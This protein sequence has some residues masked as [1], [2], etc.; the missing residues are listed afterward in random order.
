LKGIWSMTRVQK[1]LALVVVACLVGA[2]AFWLV[3]PRPSPLAASPA[4]P[5]ATA[6]S[7]SDPA[8]SAPPAAAPARR[9]SSTGTPQRLVAARV[10]HDP[11]LQH[12]AF[13]GQV[14]NFST[15]AGV[16]GAQVT[17]AHDGASQSVATDGDG[18][19]RFE[20]PAAGGYVLAV[21]TK[22]GFLPFAPEWGTSPI[23]L[24]ARPGLHIRDVTIYLTPA[25][26]YTG[27]VVDPDGAP[28]AG[29][30]V[31]LVGVS[32][33]QTLVPLVDRFVSDAHGEFVF[34]A[35][36]DALLEARKEGY[37]PGR[38]RLAS[39]AQ[40]A[41]R[42]TIALGRAG[43]QKAGR[44]AQQITGRV[45][46]FGGAPVKSAIVRAEPKGY[47]PL[48]MDGEVRAGDDGRFVLTG[49][50]PGEYRVHAGCPGCTH[51]DATVAAGGDV[52]LRLE[53]GGSLAGRV[54]DQS[55]GAVASFT[56]AVSKKTGPL[57]EETVAQATVI[58]A[59]GHFQV[60][61]L[62]PG[63]LLVRATGSGY[64]PSDPVSALVASGDDP[65][66][67]TIR[68]DKG[69]S[70]AGRVVD[71]GTRAPLA[72]ARVSIESSIGVGSSAVPLVAN[73]LTDDQG[74]FVLDGLPPG[75][76]TATAAAYGHN[77]VM[78]SGLTIAEGQVLAPIV[79]ELSPTKDGEEPT[80]EMAGIG[81]VL[82]AQGERL[83][84]QKVFPGG[85]A[86]LAGL[87][88]GDAVLGIDGVPVVTLGMDS[89]IQRIRGPENS[90]VLLNV[91]RSS[92]FVGPVP[93]RR[94]RVT[95]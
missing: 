50:D 9:S 95:F 74:Q 2:G 52:T 22:D 36:D 31:R 35:H 49:L 17:F 45:V 19:F 75:V 29:A 16:A 33:E 41:H 21:V 55:G 87:G 68:V 65:T 32:G 25:I 15:G 20:P 11:G 34:H 73:T 8:A 53:P 37:D 51:A 71:R 58:D 78:K 85:G 60:D 79:F 84:I 70:L 81:A 48:V 28:V 42:L 56:V 76:R 26:D 83:V 44:G 94:V 67:V 4:A 1:S 39:G 77:I 38:A 7:T 24:S 90:V 66:E 47:D 13:S 5:A 62:T 63:E 86:E 80:T 30:D 93:V 3:R 91:T 12:G 10:E 64:A 82:A 14:R 59:E 23:A 88:A 89:A 72:L 61:G 18:A 27:I 43:S 46:D 92:G 54:T 6:P 69:G 40:L 57:V